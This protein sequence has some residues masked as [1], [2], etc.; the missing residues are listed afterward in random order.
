MS[1]N[2]DQ[3]GEKRSTGPNRGQD[4]QKGVLGKGGRKGLNSPGGK[5]LPL[6][7][8]EVSFQERSYLKKPGHKEGGREKEKLRRK[9]CGKKESPEKQYFVQKWRAEDRN[10]SGSHEKEPGV[11]R[12]IFT[13]GGIS[14]ATYKT[15]EMGR[16]GKLRR[17]RK[18]HRLGTT[19]QGGTM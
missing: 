17:K 5:S 4:L 8:R 14:T 12:E 13:G 2:L 10:P 7:G 18:S 6:T 9:F 15:R 3:K 11:E 1:G 16:V 19:S